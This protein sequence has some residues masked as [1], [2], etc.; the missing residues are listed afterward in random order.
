MSVAPT[1]TVTRPLENGLPSAGEGLLGRLRNGLSHGF[2]QS[3][4][5]VEVPAAVHSHISSGDLCHAFSAPFSH[6][7]TSPRAWLFRRPLARPRRVPRTH[8]VHA[9][10]THLLGLAAPSSPRIGEAPETRARRQLGTTQPPGSAGAIA[11]RLTKA[12][13]R[14]APTSPGAC[15]RGGQWRI[16]APC[17]PLAVSAPRPRGARASLVEQMREV[18]RSG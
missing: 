6:R 7:S 5:Q 2:V 4:L 1:R 16:G 3:L 14:T 12:L 10:G 13:V 11:E 17:V 15:R 18:A 8:G 9:P